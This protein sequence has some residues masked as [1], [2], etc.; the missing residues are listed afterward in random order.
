MPCFNCSD[1]V[2]EIIL[3]EIVD[4]T[5]VSGI[6]QSLLQIDNGILFVYDLS[7]GK[8][9]S[10]FRATLGAGEKGRVKNKYLTV[11]D[12]QTSN[13]SGYRLA[14]DA[15]LTAIAIQ[16]RE[17]ETWTLHVR[18]NDLPTNLASLTMTG[19]DGNHSSVIN[20]N[21]DEGD[22]LHFYAE[23]TSFFGIKDPLI[24]VEIAWR[25]DTIPSP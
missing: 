10:S 20:V 7:R 22:R 13:L 8:W 23:T 16:T 2:K 17:S 4:T 3:H 14:R 15:T 11:F 9:L 19:V 25:N 6:D 12:G 21:L 1:I 18:K 24:W 5:T